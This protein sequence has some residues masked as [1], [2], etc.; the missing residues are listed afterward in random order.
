VTHVY[1]AAHEY[2]QADSASGLALD[3]MARLPAQSTC[4]LLVLVGRHLI[5]AAR[6]LGHLPRQDL[7]EAESRGLRSLPAGACTALHRVGSP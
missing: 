6:V 7:V 1:L 3:V 4:G 2:G 5:L